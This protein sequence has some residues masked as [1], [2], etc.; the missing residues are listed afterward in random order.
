MKFKKYFSYFRFIQ[1]HWNTYLAAFSIYHEVR[2][3]KKYDLNT[4]AINNLVHTKVLGSRAHAYIYQAVNY[5]MLEKAF[6]YLKE[7]GYKGGLVDYGCGK[8][9]ILVVAAHYGFTRITG[10]EFAPALCQQAQENTKN[11][12]SS[13][14][15]TAFTIHCM[16]AQDLS[17]QP[18]DCIFTFFNPFD[19]AI[20]LPVVKN[21]M[22]SHQEFPRDMVVCYFNPTEKEIFLSAGFQECWYYSKI[23]YLDMSILS[24][25]ALHL[26]PDN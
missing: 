10:V 21:I 2:G 20:M 13:F 19:K 23:N 12:K 1:Q 24:L 22:Q 18:E 17:I 16:D 5:Y 15:N 8:G 6:D 7:V 4:T 11:L 3:E 9:R 26:N 14:P 25:E